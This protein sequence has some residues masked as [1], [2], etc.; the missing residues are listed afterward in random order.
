MHVDEI[1][2]NCS[3]QQNM[4]MHCANFTLHLMTKLKIPASGVDTI[5][6]E[7][8]NLIKISGKVKNV[9]DN[10]S[11]LEALNNFHMLKLRTSFLTK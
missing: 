8:I 5:I 4:D 3:S 10:T 1:S 11:M 7:T 2:P 6:E 9:D